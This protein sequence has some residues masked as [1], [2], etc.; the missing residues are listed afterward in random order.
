MGPVTPVRED[1]E[2]LASTCVASWVELFDS[3]FRS[4]SLLINPALINSTMSSRG[5]EWPLVGN[6]EV[7][8]VQGQFVGLGGDQVV[9]KGRK[10]MDKLLELGPRHWDG[11]RRMRLEHLEEL[12]SIAR[13]VTRQVMLDVVRKP[14][15]NSDD[16]WCS[17]RHASAFG[18]T[19]S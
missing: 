11:D 2:A 6:D 13:Q 12:I 17:R 3:C 4:G 19:R 8:D 15:A 5:M 7:R 14:L 10:G 1:D 16:R 9:L 18:P